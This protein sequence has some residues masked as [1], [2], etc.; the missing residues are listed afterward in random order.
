M[1]KR[2]GL[3]W[4]VRRS[5]KAFTLIELLVVIAIIAVLIAL[6]LPA[7]QQAREAARRTQCKNN[8]KQIGLALH[9]YH[10]TFGVFPYSTG[11][12]GPESGIPLTKNQTGW[13]LLLSYFDQGP[14]YNSIDN[15]AAMGRYLGPSWMNPT[16]SPLASGGPTAANAKAASAKLNMLLCPSDPGPQFVNGYDGNYGCE[17][18]VISYK[19][20]Y[21]FCV[22]SNG[23]FGKLRWNDPSQDRKTRAMFGVDANSSIRDVSDGTSN[24][25]AISET[26]LG[27]IDGVTG[28]W[29]CLQH[30]GGGINFANVNGQRRIND[31]D[32]CAWTS[33][34]YSI[35]GTPGTL[36]EWGTPGSVHTGGMQ[37]TMGDGSVRFLSENL[38]A[39][40][41]TRLGYIADGQVVGEF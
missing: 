24:T 2:T 29:G 9:N 18:S 33:P 34:P 8:L 26:T 10:D 37:V 14:L 5:Y 20:S 36:G 23:S 35:L 19:S 11:A 13:V 7:V 16:P 38:D 22:D 1:R 12:N 27:V 39:T 30:V 6:L 40:T 4:K 28:S 15:N 21:G 25:V 41:R 32:C 31:W 17:T 3:L